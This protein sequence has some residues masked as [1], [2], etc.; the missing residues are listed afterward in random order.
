MPSVKDD[1]GR[2]SQQWYFSNDAI[3]HGADELGPNSSIPEGSI[4]VIIMNLVLHTRES[5]L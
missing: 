2:K 1:V 4:A 3:A 5:Q